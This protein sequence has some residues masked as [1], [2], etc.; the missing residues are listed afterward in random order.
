MAKLTLKPIID[1]AVSLARRAASRKGFN[2]A[3]ILGDSDVIPQ[4]ERIR[5]YATADD[6]IQDGFKLDSPE[7]KAAQ[8]YFSANMAPT[9][10]FVGAKYSTDQDLLSAARACREANSE[11]YVLIPLGATNEDLLALAPWVESC[12]TPT[13]LAYTTSDDDNLFPP[14]QNTGE[15][16]GKDREGIFK[17]LHDKKY[18]R[19][20]GQYCSQENFPAVAA[21][22]GYAM[23]AN[24]GTNNSAYTLAYK[25]LPGVTPDDLT[26]N[27]VAYVC[28]TSSSAGVNG[29]VYITRADEYNVLQQGRMADGTSFDEILNLDMLKDR[30][31]LSV[32][33]L[34][35]SVPKL[36]QTD[37]GV[38]AI[39]NVINKELDHF[40]NIGFIAPG[41]WNGD[42]CLTLT[43]GK[44]LEKGYTVMAE[45]IDEQ[46]Q[47]DRD[48]RKAP[49]IYVC[50]KL[51]GAIEYVIIQVNVNR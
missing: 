37:A 14:E 26:E 31:T 48:A 24:R 30:I 44:T 10:L 12:N 13:L 43:K 41:T 18:R 49:P 39:I 3:L 38:T 2:C 16:A 51:A 46:A 23:G 50:V 9:K 29:N 21:T 34:L 35:T 40:V 33:D 4:Q 19:S 15:D 5:Q 1:I 22:M 11:W 28:G 8:L 17:K 6:L 45:S 32:M 25:E 20:F 42:D 7:Y 36:P 27:Q 47:A